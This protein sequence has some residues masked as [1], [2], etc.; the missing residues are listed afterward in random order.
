MVTIEVIVTFEGGAVGMRI[1]VTL[2]DSDIIGQA[3][4]TPH[5]RDDSV[6]VG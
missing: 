3:H 1:V 6:Y 5:E 4:V 2:T